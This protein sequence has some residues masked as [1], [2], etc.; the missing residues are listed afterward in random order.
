LCHGHDAGTGSGHTVTALYEIVPPGVAVPLGDAG[1]LKYQG[2]RSD[3]EA[4]KSGEWL[5]LR[6]RDKHPDTDEAREIAFSLPAAGLRKAGSADFRF[7]AS[8]AAFALLLRDSEYKG[9]AAWADVKEWAAASL[10]PDTKGYRRD[11]VTLVG[12]ADQLSR[13]RD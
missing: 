10:G 12:Q 6:M 8:V 1:D 11:F 9:S 13:K 2:K 7:A 4:A 3:T 5:T